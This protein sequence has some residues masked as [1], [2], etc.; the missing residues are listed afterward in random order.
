MTEKQIVE[1]IAAKLR[2]AYPDA[3]SVTLFV[4]HQE[5]S[6]EVRYHQKS[7]EVSMRQ[8]NGEW[9]KDAITCPHGDSWDDCPDCRH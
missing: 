5:A 6:I 4:N 1:S 2:A 7:N 9:V 3:V 8:L